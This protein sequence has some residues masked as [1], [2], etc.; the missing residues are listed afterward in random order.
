MARRRGWRS[1]VSITA[2]SRCRGRSS[3]LCF[4]A[5]AKMQSSKAAPQ[6]HCSTKTQGSKPASLLHCNGQ[7]AELETRVSA[8]YA[9]PRCRAWSLRLSHLYNTKT[10]S[11][12]P[13]F[14]RVRSPCLA[15]FEVG[16]QQHYNIMPK[17]EAWNPR[18]NC[19]EAQHLGYNCPHTGSSTAHVMRGVNPIME[20][21]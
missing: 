18:F 13:A 9:T 1:R 19:R 15:T 11:S 10:Q 21:F 14:S 6:H 3:R 20:S 4:T 17:R 12:K 7:D 5:M 16:I 8:I 2:V